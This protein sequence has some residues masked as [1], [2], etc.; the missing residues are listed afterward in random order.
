VT[1]NGMY[2]GREIKI[3]TCED[4]LYLR[5]DQIGLVQSATLR[6]LAGIRFPFPDEDT[7]APGEFRDA[8]RRF[9]VWGIEPPVSID[10]SLVQFKADAGILV[11]LPCPY[12]PEGKAGA[13]RYH[14]N[15]YRGPAQVAQQRVWEG[16]WATV[17]SCG[18]C[19]ALW[20]MPTL[21]DAMPVITALI[22]EGDRRDL[23]RNNGG[24]LWN[25]IAL[26]IHKGYSTPVAPKGGQ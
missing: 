5:P 14:F 13:V 3:G 1:E 20:R 22:A 15:G 16:V 19:G 4:M 26:R 10:H 25:T 11:S 17:M 21:A 12:S 8:D 9:P 18:G 2:N 24:R 7:I 6:D 23:E